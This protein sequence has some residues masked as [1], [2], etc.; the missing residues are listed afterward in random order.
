MV[1]EQLRGDDTHMM[2]IEVSGSEYAP[3]ADVLLLDLIPEILGVD[4]FDGEVRGHGSRYKAGDY[5]S[6]I[7]G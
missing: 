6:D 1:S 3:V 5:G 7:D 2:S 4:E